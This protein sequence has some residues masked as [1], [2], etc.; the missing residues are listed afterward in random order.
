M[1]A[2]SET[3]ISDIMVNKLETI[4]SSSTAQDAAIKMRDRQI[5]SVLVIDDKD[6]RPM[7]II[8]ER[9]LS[10]K[11]CASDKSSRELLTGQIMSSP[12]ITINTDSLPSYAA[13]LMLKNKVRHLLVVAPRPKKKNLRMQNIS[14]SRWE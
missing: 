1:R 6:G 9:D 3:K 8:T 14:Q 11:I 7:G 13:D 10:R 2:S 5:S 12:L 4:G